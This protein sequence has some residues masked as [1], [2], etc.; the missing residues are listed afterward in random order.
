M[1]GRVVVGPG[2][3][4]GSFPFPSDF[5]V[6]M[7]S[8]L[9][10]VSN[11]SN[12][13]SSSSTKIG[14]LLLLE[15]PLLVQIQGDKAIFAMLIDLISATLRVFGVPFF[16]VVGRVT[17]TAILV[18]LAP[19]GSRE[20]ETDKLKFPVEVLSFSFLGVR[21]SSFLLMVWPYLELEFMSILKLGDLARCLLFI[22][23]RAGRT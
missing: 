13:S 12:T 11:Q 7:A 4:S 16:S 6:S 8:L 17:S 3:V 2:C 19:T 15:D 18:R 1:L 23:M 10:E 22:P 21:V 5:T 20:V 9:G 14:F